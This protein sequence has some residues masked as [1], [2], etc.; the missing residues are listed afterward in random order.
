[1]EKEKDTQDLLIK[2][3]EMLQQMDERFDRMNQRF[4]GLQSKLDKIEN[5]MGDNK[6]EILKTLKGIE[7]KL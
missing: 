1:M 4:D 3:N 5:T 6:K 7:F 2:I